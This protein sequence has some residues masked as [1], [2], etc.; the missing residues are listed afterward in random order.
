MRPAVQ[1]VEDLDPLIWA[2]VSHDRP[3]VQPRARARCRDLVRRIGPP[4]R[5][6][7]GATHASESRLHEPPVRRLAGRADQWL[8]SPLQTQDASIHARHGP[9]VGPGY[10]PPQLPA[11]LRPRA[12]GQLTPPAETA[13][14]LPRIFK[15]HD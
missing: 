5:G 15:L 13:S 2:Y 6:L 11:N 9:E 3:P 14:P 7:D 8:G 12:H 10:R 4:Q 1:G